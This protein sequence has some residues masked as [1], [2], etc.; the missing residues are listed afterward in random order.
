MVSETMFDLVR[1]LL[2]EDKRL[3]SEDGLL[4]NKVMELALKQ[5]TK[6]IELLLSEDRVKEHFFEE[7]DE[8]LVFDK[9]KFI[10]GKFDK[11]SLKTCPFPV[12]FTKKS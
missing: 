12:V 11:I 3:T 9:D 2:K 1:E 7:V 5:D 10:I 8:A 4:K 6:L